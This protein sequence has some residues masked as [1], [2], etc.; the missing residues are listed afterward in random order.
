MVTA[1]KR[2]QTGIPGPRLHNLGFG[3]L[4]TVR[5]KTMTW[6]TAAE[7]QKRKLVLGLRHKLRCRGSPLALLTVISCSASDTRLVI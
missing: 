1:P 2:A 6:V 7:T 4:R 3:V 5:T